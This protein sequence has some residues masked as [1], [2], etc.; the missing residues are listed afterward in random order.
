MKDPRKLS[1][2]FLQNFKFEFPAES[3]GPEKEFLY[4]ESPQQIFCARTSTHV[5][6]KDFQITR[7]GRLTANE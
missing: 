3:C 5:F 7:S 4:V 2:R 6:S 1:E